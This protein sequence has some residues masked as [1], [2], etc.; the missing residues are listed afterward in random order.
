M[1]CTTG[2]T[3]SKRTSRRFIRCIANGRDRCACGSDGT[4]HDG[5]SSDS[6]GFRLSARIAA[7]AAMTTRVKTGGLVLLW[8]ISGTTLIGAQAQVTPPSAYVTFFLFDA[9]AS[10][11]AGLDA[12]I[13]A[14]IEMELADKGLI[15][16]SPDDAEAIVITHTATREKHSRD[17]MYDGWGGWQWRAADPHARSEDYKPGTLVVDMFDAWSKQLLWHGASTPPSHSSDRA[18]AMKAVAAVFR[19]FPEPD[20]DARAQTR[21]DLVRRVGAGRSMQILFSP[22]PAV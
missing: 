15:E 11:G 21:S 9:G 12:G 3:S 5:S 6:S 10:D 14:Q 19:T 2:P 7:E 18:H 1:N 22:S 17:S 20:V 13:K 4:H 8:V 16:T